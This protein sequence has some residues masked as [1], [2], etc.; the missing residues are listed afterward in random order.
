VGGK[1]DLGYL[2]V[3]IIQKQERWMA[4]LVVSLLA[5]AALLVRI[6]TPLKNIWMT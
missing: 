6:Q 2:S 3:D 1:R 4:K 5:T